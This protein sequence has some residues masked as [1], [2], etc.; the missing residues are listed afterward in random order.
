MKQAIQRAYRNHEETIKNF[1]WRALQIFGKY[2]FAFINFIVFVK[3]LTPYDFGLYGYMMASISLLAMFAD[4]G[5]SGSAAKYIAEY[6]ATN[7]RKVKKILYTSGI[8]ILGL[9]IVISILTVAFGRQFLEEQYR[10]IIYILPILILAPLVGLYSGIYMGLKRFRELAIAAL[11]SGTLSVGFTYVLI[12]GYGLI[13]ALIA[14]DIFY[15]ILLLMLAFGYR[16]FDLKFDRALGKQITKYAVIIG[17]TTLSF[18]LYSR[19]DVIILGKFGYIQEIGYYNILNKIFEM[20]VLPFTIYG[21]VSGPTMAGIYA[22]KAY[23]RVRQDFTKHVIWL[24][25]LGLVIAIAG[26][27]IIPIIISL[28]FKEYFVA[29]TLAMFRLLIFLVPIRIV[30]AYANAGH[31]GPTGNAHFSLYPMIIAGVANVILDIYFIGLYGFIGVVYSTLGCYTF[32][33]GS[34]T[35]MYYRKLNKLT[36]AGAS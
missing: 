12:K 28:F 19:A 23:D 33:I 16:G 25:L 17:I 9:G 4:F 20:I 7:K 34:F 13:G 31:T 36:A 3:I 18:Y 26:Y 14:Q 8:I 21:Q 29:E 5:I 32:A 11:V 27:F 6:N 10:Y 2:G 15:L 24:L 1:F 35:Y 30:A 22:R